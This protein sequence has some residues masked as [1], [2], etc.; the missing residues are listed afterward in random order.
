MTYEAFKIGNLVSLKSHAYNDTLL[1]VIITGDHNS[2]PPIMIIKE[3]RRLTTTDTLI[4]STNFIF[5]CIWFSSKSNSLQEGSFKDIHLKPIFSEIEDSDRGDIPTE[6]YEGDM[7]LLKSTKLELTKRKS[8]FSVEEGVSSIGDSKT[9]QSA[10]LTHLPPVFHVISVKDNKGTNVSEDGELKNYWPFKRKVKCFYYNSHN[11]KISEVELPIEA[12]EK[13]VPLP[14][15]ILIDLNSFIANKNYISFTVKGQN[16]QILEPTSLSF[17]SGFY[18]LKAYNIIEG[19]S[20]EI[21]ISSDSIY[22]GVEEPV[23]YKSPLAEMAYFTKDQILE[24]F[25]N[26]IKIAQDH[27]FYLRIKYVNKNA[28]VTTR[29]ISKSF[30][31]DNPL[32]ETNP[33][34]FTGHCHL[35][36]AQRTFNL[37]RVQNLEVFKVTY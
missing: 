3:I 25:I 23:L 8:T 20:K 32:K 30:F 33:F 37:S 13:L 11:E 35:R 34:Y 21:L 31:N 27:K 2:L 12:L 26:K 28:E 24:D 1:G 19:R 6:I 18:F 10:L 5:K 29:V 4:Q 22:S 15:Q 17:R 9:I 7:V 16:S 14:D 36:N